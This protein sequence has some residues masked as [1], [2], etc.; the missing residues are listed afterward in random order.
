[1]NRVRPDTFNRN[2]GFPLPSNRKPWIGDEYAQ[3]TPKPPARCDAESYACADLN[4][5]GSARE[6][7]PDARQH[8][9]TELLAG[10]D[11]APGVEDSWQRLERG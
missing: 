4:P 5:D 8:R 10:D 6:L 1:L 2:V 11:A 9:E 3:S 7:H